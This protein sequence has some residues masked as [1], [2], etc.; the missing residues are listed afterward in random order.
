MYISVPS[1]AQATVAEPVVQLT[2]LPQSVVPKPT[3]P[4]TP[5][6][7]PM[8]QPIVLLEPL[9]QSSLNVPAKKKSGAGQPF[10]RLEP[11]DEKV[12][13]VDSVGALLV[14]FSIVFILH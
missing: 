5:K 13:M 14:C 1:P 2:K 11:L 6:Y 3:A 9:S 12:R 4:N 10:V 8:K 7:P